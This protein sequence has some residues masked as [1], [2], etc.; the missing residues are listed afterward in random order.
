LR[1]KTPLKF[2]ILAEFGPE[3]VENGE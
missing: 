2:V 3:E 1:S